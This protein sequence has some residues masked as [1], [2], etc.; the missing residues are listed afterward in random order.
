[1]RRR[2]F[3]RALRTPG[4]DAQ[5]Q[6]ER[7]QPNVGDWSAARGALADG[8]GMTKTTTKG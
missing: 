8:A 6:F 2:A 5:I 7:A 4:I 1:V 3:A